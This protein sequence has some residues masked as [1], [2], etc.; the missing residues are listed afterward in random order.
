MND[1][2]EPVCSRS[3]PLALWPAW[4]NEVRT[5]SSRPNSRKAAMIDTSVRK[6]R[7]LRR[8]SDAHT[9]W[10]YFMAC[11]LRGDHR[12]RML[13]E[14]SFVAL[15]RLIGIAGRLRFVGAHHVG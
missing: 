11:S 14:R 15:Q 13:D 10:R 8:N 1:S 9:R 2:F 12:G 3:A 4:L 6:V 5:A 7:V